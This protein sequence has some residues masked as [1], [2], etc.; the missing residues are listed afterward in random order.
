M[1]IYSLFL[2]GC[3]CGSSL[4]TAQEPTEGVSPEAKKLVETT[5]L[6]D[7]TKAAAVAAFQPALA[8]MKA[9]GLTEIGLDKVR[10]AVDGFFT[11][12]FHDPRFKKKLAEAYAKVFTKSELIELTAFY[13]TATGKKALKMMPALLNQGLVIGEEFAIET[14]PGFEAKLADIMK[15]HMPASQ[16]PVP[17]T[18]AAKSHPTVPADQ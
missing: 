7:S 15:E 12:I 6:G 3:L 1:K 18:P 14:A 10:A 13:G 17:Q 16:A 2:I 5:E 11:N 8:Q 9:Q 4:V